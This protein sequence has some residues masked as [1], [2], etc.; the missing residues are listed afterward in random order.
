MKEKKLKLL[1]IAVLAVAVLFV[2]GGFLKGSPEEGQATEQDVEQAEVS[3][4]EVSGSEIDSDTLSVL[5]LTGDIISIDKGNQKIVLATPQYKQEF[6]IYVDDNT[7]TFS[8][9]GEGPPGTREDGMLISSGDKISWTELK[10]GDQI[11]VASGSN[12]FG[13]AEFRDIKIIHVIR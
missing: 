10:V 4:S 5:A 13:L 12:M 3:E 8:V 9:N 2:L 11:R 7:E 1:L 6:V